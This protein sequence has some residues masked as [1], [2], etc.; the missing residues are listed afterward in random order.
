MRRLV[1][2]LLTAGL[3]A[4]LLVAIDLAVT[5]T[6]QERVTDR[7]SAAL[8]APAEAEVS[9]WPV[10]L[11]LLSGTLPAVHVTA[12]NV[13]LNAG[14]AV[15]NDLDVRLRDVDLSWDDLTADSSQLPPADEAV[16]EAHLDQQTAQAL[17]D[18]REEVVAVE[19][20]EGTVALDLAG[21]VHIEATVDAE[22]GQV[23]LRPRDG[24][25]GFLG[26][27]EVPIDLSDQPGSPHVQE[28]RVTPERIVLFGTL[29]A[30]KPTDQD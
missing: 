26:L 28:V 2:I 19:L 12:R 24:I 20:R 10:T 22:D 1:A 9:G 3:V 7:V 15:I 4:A 30:M 11:H 18:V 13:P 17:L 16:F 5:A 29:D 6:T 27:G 21:V 8:D 25:A 23:V 14:E